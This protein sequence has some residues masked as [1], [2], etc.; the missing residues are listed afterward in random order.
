MNRPYIHYEITMNPARR[1]GLV[2]GIGRPAGLEPGNLSA[3]DPFH[4]CKGCGTPP[5][6][7]KRT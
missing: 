1:R 6:R 3:L 4:G 7:R 2:A 5:L